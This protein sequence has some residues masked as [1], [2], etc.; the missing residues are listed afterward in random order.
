[1][2]IACTKIT[3]FLSI[4]SWPRSL[5]KLYESFSKKVELKLKP[6]T[7]E[8]IKSK[9]KHDP[10]SAGVLIEH[11]VSNN[12]E[13]T[14][15]VPE[16]VKQDLQKVTNKIIDSKNVLVKYQLPFVKQSGKVCINCCAD[17]VEYPLAKSAKCCNKKAKAIGITDFKVVK[18]VDK[19]YFMQLIVYSAGLYDLGHRVKT[20]RIIDYLNGNVH[21]CKLSLYNHIV[22]KRFIRSHVF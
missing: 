4:C 1:M 12:N 18:A 8:F 13:N 22:I 5:N 6:E 20:L 17:V 11:I 16:S 21:T 3:E 2:S 10:M 7:K 15:S 19:K 9:H 14:V